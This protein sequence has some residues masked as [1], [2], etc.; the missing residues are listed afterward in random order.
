MLVEPGHPLP[1]LENSADIGS[2]DEGAQ[3]M[4]IDKELEALRG[5]C[6]EAVLTK[7]VSDLERAY[8]SDVDPTE[9]LRT[10]GGALMVLKNTHTYVTQTGVPEALDAVLAEVVDRGECQV[11]GVAI[12]S[13]G[14][15]VRYLQ[16]QAASVTGVV[17]T[18]QFPF[19]LN[20]SQHNNTSTWPSVDGVRFDDAEHRPKWPTVAVQIEDGGTYHMPM[21]D[22]TYFRL[23][24]VGGDVRGVGANDGVS[25]IAAAVTQRVLKG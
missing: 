6:N 4:P 17:W 15:D 2:G 10:I 19:E 8:G 14:Q 21:V 25:H 22:E 18:D 9:R 20:F 1:V 3:G 11:S 16:G 24:R 23:V 7:V 12:A 13:S 5:A